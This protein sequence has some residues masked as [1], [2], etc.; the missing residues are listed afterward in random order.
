MDMRRVLAVLLTLLVA[1]LKRQQ[2]ADAK[3]GNFYLADRR[4]ELYGEL[5]KR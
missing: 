1:T 2:L 3:T 5:S 4:P